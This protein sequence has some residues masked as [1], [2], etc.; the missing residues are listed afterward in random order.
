M[1]VFDYLPLS[2]HEMK[3]LFPEQI[4]KSQHL[5]PEVRNVFFE[6][7]FSALETH[8]MELKLLRCYGSFLISGAS[9]ER[10][11]QN[12]KVKLLLTSYARAVP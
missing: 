12:N 7:Q 4:M 2:P 8:W 1:Y 9:F 5:L 3:M 11:A 10:R 6:V